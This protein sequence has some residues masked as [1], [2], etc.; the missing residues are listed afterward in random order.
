MIT[1]IFLKLKKLLTSHRYQFLYN[2]VELY[3]LMLKLS[4]GQY[5]IGSDLFD[6]WMHNSLSSAVYFH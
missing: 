3:V 1:S 6:L 4:Q 2:M 5:L